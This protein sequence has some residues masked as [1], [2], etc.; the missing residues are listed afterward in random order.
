MYRE[1]FGFMLKTYRNDLINV[2]RLISS[3]VLFNDSNLPLKIVCSTVDLELFKKFVGPNISILEEENIPVDL[4]TDF[5]N[6]IRPG[7]INQ[8]ILKLAFWRTGFFKH[9]LCLDSDAEF[10]R[11]IKLS[12]YMHDTEN[13]YTIL[14]DDKDLRADPA[15]RNMWLSR[16]LS[17]IKIQDFLGMDKSVP[18]PTC[19]GFQIIQSEV[20]RSFEEQVLKGRK[21]TYL[22]LMKI[23]PYE[24]SWYNYYL[25][26][27]ELDIFQIEPLF[28]YFHTP[29]Q[30]LQSKIAN[31]TKEDLANSY[32]GIIMTSNFTGQGFDYNQ[33]RFKFL[34]RYLSFEELLRS[35]VYKLKIWSEGLNHGTRRRV[36][37]LFGPA[38][39][40]Y[41]RGV[42]RK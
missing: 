14:H 8:E 11:P 39:T 34:A 42:L 41:I 4:A 28:K 6:G 21:L 30:L 23:S 24:F 2:E 20:M 13:P 17:L 27:C 36:K 9:Y 5:V 7:Y 15:Y 29:S 25:Q 18:W 35:C 1:T 31:L 12:D 22:D 19:H 3:Y 16:D 40:Q 33:S 32:C 26:S 37:R 38:N 10:I